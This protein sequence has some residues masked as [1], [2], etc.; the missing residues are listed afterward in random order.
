MKKKLLY[1]LMGIVFALSMVGF[2]ACD[3]DDD[4]GDGTVTTTETK[5]NEDGTTTTTTTTTYTDGS[6]E[7]TAV[8]TD[9]DGN[10]TSSTTTTTDSDGNTTTTETEY[11]TDKEGNSVESTEAT[12]SDGSTASTEK[13]VTSDTTATV[14]VSPSASGVIELVSADELS[15]HKSITLKVTDCSESNTE[16][17]WLLLSS[18][19]NWDNKIEA[20]VEW[21]SDGSIVDDFEYTIDA[22]TLVT[23]EVYFEDGL[24]IS[25][26]IDSL[27]IEYTISDTLSGTEYTVAIDGKTGYGASWTKLSDT[28]GVGDFQLIVEVPNDSNPVYLSNTG[29]GNVSDGNYVYYFTSSGDYTCRSIFNVDLDDTV[30]LY[31]PSDEY[32]YE[33]DADEAFSNGLWIYSTSEDAIVWLG[34]HS[35]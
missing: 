22:S 9:E 18:S 10:V 20:F 35:E 17:M 1:G 15:G 30:W 8:T 5:E 33:T 13:T 28:S 6:S 34:T 16:G 4:D 12:F 32:W 24:F 23:W 29:E 26:N 7:S 31:A 11:S 3:D 27:T 25:G 19:A 14:T 2:V 21:D